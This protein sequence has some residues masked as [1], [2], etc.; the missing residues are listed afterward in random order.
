MNLSTKEIFQILFDRDDIQQMPAGRE[1]DQEIEIALWTRRPPR[2]RTENAHARGPVCLGNAQN[3]L[4]CVTRNQGDVHNASYSSV[5][6]SAA[7]VPVDL[8]SELMIGS[9]PKARLR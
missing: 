4:T 9:E 1:V 7:K 6:V 5:G 2:D 8:G 3:F